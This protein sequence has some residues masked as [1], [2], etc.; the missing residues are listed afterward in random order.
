MALTL[1]R[2]SF[3]RYCIMDTKIEDPCQ[4]HFAFL[5]EEKNPFISLKFQEV[6]DIFESF[7]LI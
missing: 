6:Y 7:R 2:Y 3:P 1:V 4:D 5:K